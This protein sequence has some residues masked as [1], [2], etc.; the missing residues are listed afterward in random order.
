MALQFVRDDLRQH[1][2]QASPTSLV[3]G[4]R[5]HRDRRRERQPDQ[6]GINGRCSYCGASR[7]TLD[8]QRG[9]ETH[10]Y[11]FRHT[12]DI[13]ARIAELFGD[14]MQFDVI[15][16]NPPYQLQSDGGTPGHSDLSA[17][18]RASENARTS[19]PRHGHSV[20]VDGQRARLG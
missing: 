12:D 14:D 2:V 17:L 16:G 9:L 5:V 15:I 6:E 11:A 7:A 19:V 18:C 4:N 3:R 8:R 13:N 1:L 10:A 20:Q